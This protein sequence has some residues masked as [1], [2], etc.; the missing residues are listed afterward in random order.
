MQ[1]RDSYIHLVGPR[2]PRSQPR[3]QNATLRGIKA[4]AESRLHI[5]VVVYWSKSGH[6]R[7]D[8]FTRMRRAIRR[9][10]PKIIVLDYPCLELGIALPHIQ[11]DRTLKGGV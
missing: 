3:I 1:I 9:N 4:A 10:T 11:I 5:A 6:I 2:Q 7:N 8:D